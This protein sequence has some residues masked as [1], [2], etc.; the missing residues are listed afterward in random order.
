MPISRLDLILGRLGLHRKPRRFRFSDIP[1]E[2]GA[3]ARAFPGY[4]PFAPAGDVY[5][6]G[7]VKPARARACCA[8]LLAAKTDRL[9][10]IERLITAE[11]L[12]TAAEPAAWD[13]IG[14]WIERELEE[15]REPWCHGLGHPPL[16]SYPFRPLWH[17]LLIDLS[18]LLGEHIIRRATTPSV[19]AYGGDLD[20]PR[21][22][23]LPYPV[24]ARMAPGPQ[25]GLAPV[26]GPFEGLY[27]W[28]LQA[29]KR[30]LGVES[31]P[32]T[33]LGNI[34]LYADEPLPDSRPAEDLEAYL[35]GYL[36]AHGDLPSN[37]DLATYMVDGD[38]SVED[39]PPRF[40]A[41][42]DARDR[43]R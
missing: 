4:R 35:Q 42:L 14:A 29:L 22:V 37:D 1:A 25:S 6:D 26:Y 38:Y 12:G 39:L 33:P 27:G 23:D 40:K 19:W 9:A 41:M 31:R 34:L 10:E 3:Y 8:A 18:L 7:W 13:A 20:P 11:G 24:V 28:G 15:N 32:G 16:L 43:Q 5:T 17:G 2:E 30:R 36:D 21:W